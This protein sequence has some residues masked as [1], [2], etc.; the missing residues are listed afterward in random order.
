MTDP[1]ADQVTV[2]AHLTANPGKE[3]DLLKLLRGLL[4]P[5]RKEAGCIRYELNQEIENPLAFTFAEKFTNPNA[6]AAH[7]KM[8]HVK[9]FAEQSI[10]L[11]EGRRVRMHR[12]LVPVTGISGDKTGSDEAQI[13]VIA[14]FTAKPGKEEEL[15]TFL[16]GL[17]E[18]TRREPGCIRYELNQDLDEPATFSFVETFADRAGFDAHCRMPYID[19]LF[20]ALKLLVAEQYIGLHRPVFA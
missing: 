14:H 4:D 19:K 15:S 20:E 8:R 3:G 9:K 18:P 2:V 12:E 5:T 17:V 13:V 16:R 10:D 1:A 7:L 6:Y 11:V